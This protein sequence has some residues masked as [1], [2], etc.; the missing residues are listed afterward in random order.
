[1]LWRR[2]CLCSKQLEVFTLKT[3]KEKR[4]YLSERRTILLQGSCYA[5]GLYKKL[6]TA[7][8]SR[9][10]RSKYARLHTVSYI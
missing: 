5:G 1:M 2:W 7:V 10:L 8:F 6:P 4:L 3:S 9:K